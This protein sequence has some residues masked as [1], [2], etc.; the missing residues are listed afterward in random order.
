MSMCLRRALESFIKIKKGDVEKWI[1]ESKKQALI[2]MNMEI[3]NTLTDLENQLRFMMPMKSKYNPTDYIKALRSYGLVMSYLS[4]LAIF[5]LKERIPVEKVRSTIAELISLI[6]GGFAVDFGGIATRSK[7]LLVKMSENSS[8]IVIEGTRK[9][10]ASIIELCGYDTLSE[11]EK[12]LLREAIIAFTQSI[13]KPYTS[14]QEISIKL[15]VNEKQ[16]RKMIKE[17]TKYHPEIIMKDNIVSTR[18]KLNEWVNQTVSRRSSDK[19]LNDL[20]AIFPEDLEKA[21]V[22]NTKKIIDMLDSLLR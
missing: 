9:Y 5:S 4:E 15:G 22:E 20:R 18:A 3:V 11:E 7:E 1:Q 21:Y 16:A 2:E 8:S 14:I 13:P 12:Y 17:L 6:K 19:E 10:L